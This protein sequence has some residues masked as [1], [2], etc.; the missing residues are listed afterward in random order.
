MESVRC[1]VNWKKIGSWKKGV[2]SEGCATDDQPYSV[3]VQEVVTMPA[4]HLELTQCTACRTVP[5]LSG[6]YLTMTQ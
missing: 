3:E 4:L 6:V 5:N 1:T 2:L